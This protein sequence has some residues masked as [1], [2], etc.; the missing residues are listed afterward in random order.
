VVAFLLGVAVGL[1]VTLGHHLEHYAT[2]AELAGRLEESREH[3]RA[4]EV[5]LTVCERYARAGQL[6]SEERE[7]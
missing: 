3:L 2:A 5:S 7:P 4:V 6:Y 1:A